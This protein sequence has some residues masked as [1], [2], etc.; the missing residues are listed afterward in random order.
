MAIGSLEAGA[1]AVVLP[2]LVTASFAAVIVIARY[3]REVSMMPATCASQ[4]LVVVVCLPL[5]SLGSVDGHDWAI[6]AALGIG[7]WASASRFH[8]RRPPHPPP[9]SR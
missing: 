9:R 2:L 5:V 3:R 6:L 1:A 7:R 4:V 8:D